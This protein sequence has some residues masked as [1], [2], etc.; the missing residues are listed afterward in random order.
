[1][2][3]ALY[4]LH[5]WAIRS[6]IPLAAAV[7]SNQTAP[8]DLRVVR[9]ARRP[10][11]SAPPP[12]IPLALHDEPQGVALCQSPAGHTLRF[13]GL[14]D[15]DLDGTARRLT[16]HVDPQ[17]AAETAELLLTSSALSFLLELHGYCVLHASAVVLRQRAIAFM[18]PSGCGKSSLAAALCALGAPLISDDVLR[19]EASPAVH[20]NRGTFALRL[21]AT[22]TALA[23]LFSTPIRSVDDRIVVHAMPATSRSYRVTA[24]LA[25]SPGPHFQVTRVAGVDAIASVLSAARVTSWCSERHMNQQ[26]SALATLS[27]QVAVFRLTL[28]PT[29]LHTA[30]GRHALY[31]TIDRLV[32]DDAS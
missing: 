17:V 18:G 22:Q 14:C 13:F 27:S 3:P 5:D 26:F 24:L 21:R 23:Q 1:M 16:V 11:P 31:E 7:L 25:P 15:F 6:E 30:A 12:G 32:Q 2:I 28:P 10:I 20:C 29:L 9:G 4:H 8:L 19:I